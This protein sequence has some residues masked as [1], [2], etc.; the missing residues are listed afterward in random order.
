MHA[1][2]RQVRA[3]WLATVETDTTL[4]RDHGLEVEAEAVAIESAFAVTAV[5]VL[6]LECFQRGGT[7]GYTDHRDDT[8]DGRVVSAMNLIRNA[9]I[10]LPV[11]LDPDVHRTVGVTMADHTQRFRVF[12]TWVPYARLPQVIRDSI[13]TKDNRN[14]TRSR[15]HDHYASSLE[16]RFVVETLLD[17]VRFFDACDPTI[18]RHDESGDIDFFPLPEIAQHDYE[19]RHPAWPTRTEYEED[20]RA[21]TQETTPSGEFRTVTHVLLDDHGGVKAL[22]G[23]THHSGGHTQA[24]VETPQQVLHDTRRGYPY[25]LGEGTDEIEILD[26]NGTIGSSAG[27]LDLSRI[28]RASGDER[29]WQSWYE[30][31]AGDAVYYA[32]SRSA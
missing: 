16:G 8:D 1:L 20:L 26:V 22:C 19:R 21:R 18:T 2:Q 4:C 25:R 10:H 9:E 28:P 6:D 3:T 12:P 30:L 5:R 17:A 11:I 13:R 29:P 32:R 31:M 27:E 7:P 15:A 14:A 23:D 24:F